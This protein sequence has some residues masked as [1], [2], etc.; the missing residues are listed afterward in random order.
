MPA[1]EPEPFAVEM[2]RIAG[3][4]RRVVDLAGI[5]LRVGDEVAE[6][7]VAFGGIEDHHDRH[8]AERDDRGEIGH[9]ETEV[10]AG[11]RRHGMG[12]GI[13]QD[14]VAVRL[15]LG[16]RA[17]ADGVA[18]A[19]AVFHNDRLPELGGEL[20]GDDARHDV[21]RAA[22]GQRH[23]DADRLGRPRRCRSLRRCGSSQEGRED[24]SRGGSAGKA[25]E[26]AAGGRLHGRFSCCFRWATRGSARKMRG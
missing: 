2:R 21:A 6:L 8:V 13:D 18:G 3:A 20:I 15:R 5:G 12:R 22:G 11:R 14:G 9:L 4:R 24:G 25:Q 23:D 19:W 17:H 7:L 16:D 26:L 10:R 1:A